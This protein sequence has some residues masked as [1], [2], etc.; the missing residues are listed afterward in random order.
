MYFFGIIGIFFFFFGIIQHNVNISIQ[1]VDFDFELF[2]R[3]LECGQNECVRVF[4]CV[5]TSYS[6]CRFDLISDW[7]VDI[8]S[9]HANKGLCVCVCVCLFVCIFGTSVRLD[10]RSRIF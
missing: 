5:S 3:A 7:L 2:F 4:F 8:G 9:S 6:L 1:N 10:F